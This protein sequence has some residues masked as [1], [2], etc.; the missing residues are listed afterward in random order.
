MPKRIESKEF[1]DW[2]HKRMAEA[3]L[4]P[5]EIIDFNKWLLARSEHSENDDADETT[6]DDFKD[7]LDSKIA[8]AKLTP[9]EIADFNKWLTS[10]EAETNESEITEPEP[11]SKNVSLKDVLEFVSWTKGRMSDLIVNK[12]ERSVFT[13]WLTKRVSESSGLSEDEVKGAIGDQI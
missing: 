12:E 8:D 9:S 4:T 5:N 7:W 2:L 3:K 1:K 13:K 6:S 11:V 10:R